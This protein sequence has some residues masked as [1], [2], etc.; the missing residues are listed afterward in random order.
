MQKKNI[1]IIIFALVVVILIIWLFAAREQSTFQPSAEN[2]DLT[3]P[4]NDSAPNISQDLE[5]ID[6]GDLN[7][8]FQAIDSDLNSL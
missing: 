4:A 7:Q 8:E 2:Q 6:V 3:A 5:G 1:I